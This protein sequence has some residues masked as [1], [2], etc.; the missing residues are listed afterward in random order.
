MPWLIKR[1]CFIPRLSKYCLENVW[2]KEIK[3]GLILS[4]LLF[5]CFLSLF[6]SLSLLCNNRNHPISGMDPT[7]TWTLYGFTHDH[8]P[9]VLLFPICTL[10]TPWHDHCTLLIYLLF[11]QA[12]FLYFLYI[13]HTNKSMY[14]T[15]FL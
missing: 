9:H 5:H 4:K 14:K 6:P 7:L 1:W 15:Q 11:V 2:T 12:R 10:S 13:L 3:H 8:G